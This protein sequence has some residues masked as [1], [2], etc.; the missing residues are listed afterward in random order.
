MGQGG[1]NAKGSI[2]AQSAR[3]RVLTLLQE[4]GPMS[5]PAIERAIP[6]YTPLYVRQT[7]YALRKRGILAQIGVRHRW[8]ESL[9]QVANHG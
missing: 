6:G 2:Q 8:R 4:R 3:G 7:I 1:V 9:Y 5:G